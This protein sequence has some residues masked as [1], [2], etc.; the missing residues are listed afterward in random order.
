[1]FLPVAL[2]TRVWCSSFSG[3]TRPISKTSARRQI[4][5]V[6]CFIGPGLTKAITA[7]LSTTCMQARLLHS[8]IVSFFGCASAVPTQWNSFVK[9]L[10]IC[11]LFVLS[12]GFLC[13]QTICEAENVPAQARQ[14]CTVGS[15]SGTGFVENMTQR[16]ALGTQQGASSLTFSVT[17][18]SAGTYT[19][20]ARYT[21]ARAY[22]WTMSAYVNGRDVTQAQFP[23][24]GSW[25]T[26]ATQQTRLP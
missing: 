18:P 10:V 1:M 3:L 26:W 13:A 19:I 22:V 14:N 21:A 17:V 6:V 15:M 5:V 2:T 16:G 23:S 4:A 12:P 20:A 11:S 9:A 7:F 8:S 25:A 24:T